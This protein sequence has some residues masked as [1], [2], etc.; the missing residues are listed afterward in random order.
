MRAAEFLIESTPIGNI[1]HDPK[2]YATALKGFINYFGNLDTAESE[3]ESYSDV[4]DYLNRSGGEIY[5]VVFAN[6]PEEIKIDLPNIHWTHCVGQ[7]YYFIDNLWSNYGEGKDYAFVI[8]ATVPPNSLSNYDVDIAGNPEEQ[9]VNIV[10]NQGAIKY[11]LFKFE[12]KR[13]VPVEIEMNE[14]F[15]A[16][17]GG[18]K[19]DLEKIKQRPENYYKILKDNGFRQR[20]GGSFSTLWIH[21]NYDYILKVFVNEDQAYKMWATVAMQN[22]NNPHFP[23]FVSRKVIKITDSYYAI[24]MEKLDSV[25]GEK[26]YDN[27]ADQI[28]SCIIFAKQKNKTCAEILESGG[29]YDKLRDYIDDNIQLLPAIETLKDIVTKYSSQFYLDLSSHNIMLRGETIVLT[30]PIAIL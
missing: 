5:R 10:A 8:E 20:G 28:R 15:L 27:I 29:N 9:E 2:K 11:K 7:I 24:R 23:K 14:N 1:L 25:V 21:P 13:L 17:L 19:K 3:L 18:I 30:D 26:Y 16:E 12:G 6:S 22:Q 4:L